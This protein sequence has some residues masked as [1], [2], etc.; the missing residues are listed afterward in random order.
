MVLVD[1]LF[2]TN[3][4]AHTLLAIDIGVMGTTR[5]NQPWFPPRFPDIKQID[6]AFTSGVLGFRGLGAY[7]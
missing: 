5:K 2:Q 1:N 6:E 3:D 7:F 4:L